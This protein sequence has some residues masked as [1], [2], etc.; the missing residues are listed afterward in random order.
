MVRKISHITIVFL[1]LVL[2]MGFTVS[3]HYCG[4]S[5]VDVSVFSGTAD[6]CTSD[7]NACD[8]G[9]CCHNENHVYQLHEDY[10]SPIVLDHVAFFQVE[11]ATFCLQLL[12]ENN[13]AEV[14]SIVNHIESPPP[15]LVC[16]VLS[17]FQVY[18]L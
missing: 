11:L 17:D 12:H 1:L 3:K 10:T 16:E 14:N 15:K 9:S 7:Q 5:L 8:M 6:S 18:R 2:T 13:I 4:D